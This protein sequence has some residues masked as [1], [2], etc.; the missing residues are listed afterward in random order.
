M[1]IADINHQPFIIENAETAKT[2]IEILDAATAITPTPRA[3]RTGEQQYHLDGNAR[4]TIH[5]VPDNAV[6]GPEKSAEIIAE[7][8]GQN[9]LD[10][11]MITGGQA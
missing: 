1:I 7:I 4:I 8:N 10:H 6:A 9:E 2:L 11:R 5:V 3:F